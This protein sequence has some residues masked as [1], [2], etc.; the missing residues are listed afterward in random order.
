M[1]KTIDLFAGAGGL[2]L[3][4]RSTGQFELVAA[5]EINKSARETYRK[6]LV[7][8]P[9][10]FEFIEN[11]IGYDF[12]ALNQKFNNEIDVVIGGPPCQGFSNAN[13]QKNHLISLN[14]GLVKEYFRVIKEIKPKAFVMEN[15]SML[16]SEKHRFYESRRDNKEIQALKES[17]YEIPER[18]DGLII[19]DMKFEGINLP[20]I[21]NLN[22]D[23][24]ALPEDLAHLLNTLKKNL[25]NSRRLPKF[26]KKQS[27][28]ICNLI[29][30][31]TGSAHNTEAGKIII[32]KLI[33]IWAALKEN[34]LFLLDD[35]L[36]YVVG[37]Q[38]AITSIKEISDN[39]LIGE[40]KLKEDDDS[41]L[42]F[43]VKSYSVIDYVN[44][45]LGGQYVQKGAVL[46]AEWFG[47]PQERRRFLV[48]GIRKDIYEERGLELK[49]PEEPQGDYHINTVKEAIGDLVTYQAGYKP[50]YEALPYKLEDEISDYAR[51]MRKGST[52]VKNLITTNTRETAMSRFKKIKPGDN[53]HSLKP[54]DKDTYSDPSRTQNTIYWRLDPDKPSG[55]VLNVRK[56]MWIHPSLD[57]AITVR[58]AAR[59]QSFPDSFEFTG[60]KDS[61]YQQVGN[62]VPPLLAK[63]V[64]ETIL[65]YI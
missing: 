38:K 59:L 25:G 12:A 44:A 2:S 19:S 13:R 53:F 35:D 3:G 31:F 50:D 1:F 65:K 24:I 6:N 26:L 33:N 61:Q 18:E 7:T 49:L 52:S 39:G 47:V 62:A 17:G 14:N 40:Y 22:F 29:E 51:E 64:A 4:F 11:V 55:T 54:E 46:H 15:V 27:T 8:D 36:S 37:F 23:D 57:R 56:S 42:V 63:A 10:H 41:T 60:T 30:T 58:E 28:R 48:I 32:D 5:A 16:S 21:P 34:Q 20:D 9:E 43:N 45:I